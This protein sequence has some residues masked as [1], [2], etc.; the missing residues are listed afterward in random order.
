[1]T[2]T[3]DSR[4]AGQSRSASPPAGPAAGP[5]TQREAGRIQAGTPEALLAIVPH[6]L[7]FYPSR[8][9][10]VL[11]L[12]GQRKRVRVTFRYDLPDP[13]DGELAAD[14]AEHALAVL[15]R[16]R[17]RAA[18]LVAYGPAALVVPA[19]AAAMGC[20]LGGGVS[21]VE[22]LRA[23]AGRYWPVLS[24]D[25]D[26]SVPEGR[27]FDPCSHPAASAMTELGLTAL[28]DRA[29]LARTLLPPAGSS[30]SIRRSTELAERRLY[31]LGLK[32]CADGGRDAL[33][34]TAVAGPAAVRRAIRCYRAG[35][36]LTSADELAW[37]ALLL[38][39]LR[40][41]DDAWARMDRR[42]RA[43]HCRLWTDV[44]RG[45]ATEY[46][47]APAALLAFTAWQSGN[48]GLAAVAVDRALAARPD[49]SMALL[50][51]EA[52]AAGMPP[53][54]AKMPMTPAQVAASYAARGQAAAGEPAR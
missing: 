10:V 20:L 48:G 33:E 36:G 28:P 23:D 52:V 37:L 44:L 16:Q 30:E 8:S 38:A 39:D 35:D 21:L 19:L 47:P 17:L 53:S 42:Y 46:V 31:D 13:P 27:S 49:Y 3:S 45:A 1:M 6:L 40:V 32:Y 29:A 15:R 9:L 14:V 43:A 26:C 50:I 7:G 54:A 34:V 12:A 4:A 18:A 24:D 22:V 5:Q 2:D 11:G 41:R 25:P 51:G